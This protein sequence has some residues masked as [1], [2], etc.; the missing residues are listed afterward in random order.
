M[1]KLINE[2]RTKAGLKP[3]EVDMRLV[4]TARAKSQDMI[5]N[6]Y[7][8]HN[9]PVYGSPYQQMKAAGI[10]DYSVLGGENIAGNSSV[11][12]AH[13]AFMNSPGHWANILDPRY[14]HLGIGIVSGGPYGMMITQHF[15][16]K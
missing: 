9:S 15:A 8:G 16:G 13:K 7:F 3:L 12:A 4:Q 2:E 5:S 14:T 1:V 10:D 11:E 6:N